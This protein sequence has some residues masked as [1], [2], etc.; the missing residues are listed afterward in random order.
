MGVPILSLVMPPFQAA[1]LLRPILLMM[2]KTGVWT[3]RGWF[4]LVT[5]WH[6]L[7]SAMVGIAIGALT[8]AITT[9]AFVQLIVMRAGGLN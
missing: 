5:L 1:A 4:D 7:P 2:N 8:A 3:W 6:L 9:E